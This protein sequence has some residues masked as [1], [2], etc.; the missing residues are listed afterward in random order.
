MAKPIFQIRSPHPG[1][2]FF[3]PD[4]ALKI[5]VTEEVNGIDAASVII[6]VNDVVA[7]SGDA[8]QTGF[9]VTK[10]VITD[11]LYNGFGYDIVPD[12][13]LEYGTQPIYVYAEQA[14]PGT[15]VLE[16]LYY[17]RV[18]EAVA[19]S[20]VGPWGQGGLEDDSLWFGD[21]TDI[22]R[23]SPRRQS[24]LGGF[25]V[26]LG[27]GSPVDPID[28][29][30]VEDEGGAIYTGGKPF[31]Y[32]PEASGGL[33]REENLAGLEEL[34]YFALEPEAGFDINTYDWGEVTPDGSGP[35]IVFAVGIGHV[36]TVTFDRAMRNHPYLGG[37]L[38]PDNYLITQL[39]LSERWRVMQ[40]KWLGSTQVELITE[41][42]IPQTRSYQLAVRNVQDENGDVID[43]SYDTTTFTA[44]GTPW[45]IETDLYAFYGQQAGVDAN[46]ET[47]VPPDVDAPYIDSENPAPSQID[48]LPGANIYFEVLDNAG[49]S[50]IDLDSVDIW[51]EG[52]HAYDGFTD[53]F[54]PGYDGA[55][56]ARYSIGNG[57]GFNIDK[58]GVY[59]QYQW[60]TVRCYAEDLA[61]IA[62]VIDQTWQFRIEDT[63]APTFDNFDPPQGSPDQ[64]AT[65][66][67]GFS[68]NDI[69][70]GVDWFTANVVVD[71]TPAV[72]N[73]V[74][75]AEFSGPNTSVLPNAFNGYDVILD[76]TVNHSSASTILVSVSAEDFESNPGA[77]TWTFG[78]E[79]WQGP[80]ITPVSPLKSELEVPLDTSITFDVT[81]DSG[82]VVA[83]FTVEVDKGSGYEMAYENG[84]SPAFKTGFDGPGSGIIAIP[85]GYRVTIDPVD[86]FGPAETILV[87]VTVEDPTGNPGEVA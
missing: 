8:Q 11:A 12:A 48:I 63:T 75:Q 78:I 59:D 40:V 14:S 28:Q 32:L 77:D 61:A 41:E 53:T 62:N 2:E 45:T 6:K 55:G 31:H 72:L 74:V 33:L 70:S 52:N 15:E 36:V 18:K 85:D 19:P 25:N 16:E 87:R 30:G 29:G 10:Y 44:A 66:D 69:G 4:A 76:R 51:V 71:G 50:G 81:D 54:Q 73:G 3:P 65:V 43:P 42:F 22:P 82:I 13:D 24:F 68:V 9:A 79:D 26:N 39:P 21:V 1:T 35:R 86:D 23:A 80:I 17:F 67:I 49:G 58:V 84:G 34:L 57:Y 37:V 64:L 38:N 60:V 27:N 20:D 46:I 47:G 83:G 7:W 5:E 56:S